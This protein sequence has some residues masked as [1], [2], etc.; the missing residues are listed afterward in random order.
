MKPYS[1]AN[2]IFTFGDSTFILLNLF[3]YPIYDLIYVTVKRISNGNRYIICES[4]GKAD[5]HFIK[6][7]DYIIKA[8]NCLYE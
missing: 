6:N 2:F 4:I 1:L 8:F 5:I 3:A 7:D